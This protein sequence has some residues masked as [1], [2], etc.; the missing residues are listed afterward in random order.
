MRHT[1]QGDLDVAV[2]HGLQVVG[3]HSEGVAALG[4]QAVVLGG[5][6]QDHAGH[7]EQ[8]LD[9]HFEFLKKRKRKRRWRRSTMSVYL[10]GV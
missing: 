2:G 6:D 7:R 3:V 1:L 4:P 8:R 10:A 5:E 9:R